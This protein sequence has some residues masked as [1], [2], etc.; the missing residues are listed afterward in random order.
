MN[1]FLNKMSFKLFYRLKCIFNIFI[2]NIQYSILITI[3]QDLIGLH[4]WRVKLDYS[5]EY[6]VQYYDFNSKNCYNA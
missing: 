1:M 6:P 3:L 2:F 5:Q 4:V